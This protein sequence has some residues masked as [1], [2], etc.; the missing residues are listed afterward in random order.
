MNLSRISRA[1]ASDPA[2]KAV[3]DESIALTDESIAEVRTLSYLLHPPLIDEAGLAATLQWFVRGFETRSGIKVSL[4]VADDFQRLPPD[5]ET[6]L[7]RI[8]QEA[9]T[10]IQRHSGSP[11]ARIRLQTEDRRILLNVVDEGVGIPAHLRANEEALVA[12]GIGIAGIR[13]RARELGGHVRIESNDS[14][15]KVTVVL[16]AP[17]V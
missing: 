4:E 7:F 17:A 2:G 15:T 14:G 9:L 8:V 3:L 6:T 10:N 1:A 16:P 13:Q 11:A 5:M 12:S